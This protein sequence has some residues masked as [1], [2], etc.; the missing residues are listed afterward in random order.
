MFVDG[1][2]EET[3]ESQERFWLDKKPISITKLQGPKGD[4]GPKGYQ[5]IKRDVGLK[6]NKRVKRATGPQGPPGPPGPGSTRKPVSAT[7][8]F[9]SSA[10]SL[11]TIRVSFPTARPTTSSTF[12]PIPPG[13]KKIHYK[14]KAM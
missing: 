12:G 8:A 6:G 10:S 5:G 1:S 7:I 2:A 13:P 3:T 11:P 9:T 4:I 14:I